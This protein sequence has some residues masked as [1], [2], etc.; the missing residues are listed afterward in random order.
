MSFVLPII[1][2]VAILFIR[3]ERIAK[4]S[5]T[6]K[7]VNIKTQNVTAILVS[8]FIRKLL[9]MPSFFMFFPFYNDYKIQYLHNEADHSMSQH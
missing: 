9:E 6:K 1:V 5:R 7:V 8:K 2:A 4:Y 3:E